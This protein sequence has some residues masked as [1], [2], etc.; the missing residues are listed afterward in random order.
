[1][2]WREVRCPVTRT[3]VSQSP[4]SDWREDTAC[5]S[6]IP[7][8][9]NFCLQPLGWRAGCAMVRLFC[10]GQGAKARAR[11]RGLALVPRF[12]P[13]QT[14]GHS[15]IHSSPIIN[16]ILGQARW[17][18]RK[19]RQGPRGFYAVREKDKQ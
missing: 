4:A 18:I 19:S 11:K 15:F 14:P 12:P 3:G 16:T 17:V 2:S 7:P 8:N 5:S 6:K 13:I 9:Q 10:R 1:M